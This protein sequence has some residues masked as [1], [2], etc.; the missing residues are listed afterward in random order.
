MGCKGKFQ[1]K[2]Q[3]KYSVRGYFKQFHAATQRFKILVCH[4]RAGKT[5]AAI[6]EAIKEVLSCTKPNPRGAYIAP[7]FS[8]AKD[9]A[10]TYLKEYTRDIPGM[11]YFESELR[12]DFPTGARIKLYGAE[13]PDRLRGL[14]FD[15]AVIDE[16]AS[17][18][19][20]IWEEIVRPALSDRQGR[21]VFIGTP[22]GQDYFFDLWNDALKHPEEWYTLMLKASET[23]I[24]PPEELAA[25]LRLMD[26]STYSREFECDFT[27]SFEGAYYA[28]EIAKALASNRV[29][30]VAHDTAADVFCAWDLGISDAM[31]LWTFQ[32]IAGEWHFLKYYQNT[33]LGL[34][35]YIN[36]IKALPY[37][38]D[39]HLLPHD[40]AARELQTGKSRQLFLEER[41]FLTKVVD[42]HKIEDGINAVRMILGRCYFDAEGCN[43]GL[44]S[45]RMYKAAYNEKN[46]V[47]STKPVHDWASHAADAFR[48]GVMGID[49]Y[50]LRSFSKSDWKKPVARA[51]EGTYA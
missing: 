24:L 33:G 10:W 32:V 49:E 11:K 26:E 48:V 45:L 47:L 34:D 12:A 27:A 17:M 23:G 51:S 1:L 37:R 29:R 40:A 22:K 36:Y 7:T 15:I 21:A 9:I 8:Q 5:V 28:K 20:T 46:R 38:V 16:P 6:N 18:A 4:R 43:L 39:T 14:Y 3:I 2:I 50:H 30:P 19:P 25:N 41:G 13:N 42:K 35:H 44:N 31:A